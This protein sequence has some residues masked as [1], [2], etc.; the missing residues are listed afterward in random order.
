MLRPVL[1]LGINPKGVSST[2]LHRDLYVAREKGHISASMY[3]RNAT[4]VENEA[5]PFADYSLNV[6]ASKGT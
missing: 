1:L 6:D 4:I 2:K 5:S 3:R